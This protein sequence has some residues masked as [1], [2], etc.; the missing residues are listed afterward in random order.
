[1]KNFYITTPLYYVNDEPH[2][3][4]AYTTILADVIARSQRMQQHNVFFLTGTD[5]H[6]QKVQEAAKRNNINPQ[7]HVD[8]Y[9]K[10]FKSAWKGLNIDY[11]YFIRTTDKKHTDKVKK[12]LTYLYSKDEIYLNEY[13]GLY[14]VSEERFVT[15]KEVEEGDFREIKKLKEK[16]YFFKM[17]KY[18]EQL[19]QHINDHPDFIQPESR[20]NEILGFLK[21]PLADLCI[22]RPKERL[23]WGIELPFDDNYVTYVWFD[24]LL[25]YITGIG[26][27]ED[28]KQFNTY[29][30]ADY[31]LMA[32]DII[33]T[34]CV[35]WPTMLMACNIKLPKTIFAH[36]WW[37]IDN[38][39]MSKSLGNV[40]KPLD[41]ADQFGADAL[42]Y[43]LMRNMVLGQ[44]ATFT[45]DSF[46]ERYN[47]DLANDF[48]N[49]VNR[50]IILVHKNFDEKIP[51][52]G[53]YDDIDLELISQVKQIPNQV[54]NKYNEFKI[55]E[56]LDLTMNLFRLTNKYLEVKAPWKLIKEDKSQ[57]SQAATTLYV[58]AEILRIGA[59]LISPI[60]P[61][62]SKKVLHYL[63]TQ[64]L[65]ETSFGELEIG[66]NT[67]TPENL[68]PRIDST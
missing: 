58:A 42:R 26:W 44:D 35:Y 63:G 17:S 11:S 60:I 29:W 37:L 65:N 55:H 38:V 27:D 33:T 36:G 68:F 24:A 8:E 9:V 48:G 34:H 3:G 64:A 32:K 28:E 67:H 16:N 62:K 43:Y 31:H 19:I 56:A 53:N 25:N 47:A 61:N 21:K 22:S 2:I 46:I 18:Q 57:G 12:V 5:E 7:E 51:Q 49:L 52:Y 30:P 14:S 20:K 66:A 54:I 15:E 6:G 39:K 50:I 59:I 10:R 40:V 45:F 23:S 41:L 13:E 4:H 1:M